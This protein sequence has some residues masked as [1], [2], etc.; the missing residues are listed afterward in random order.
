MSGEVNDRPRV[1][2]EWLS[3]M[4]FREVA[5]GTRLEFAPGINLVLGMNGS[6][7]TTLLDLIAACV[8]GD[9]RTYADETFELSYGLRAGAKVYEFCVS[10]LEVEAD[11]ALREV[12]RDMP[13]AS[14]TRRA[15]ASVIERDGARERSKVEV[16]RDRVVRSVDGQSEVLELPHYLLAPLELSLPVAIWFMGIRRT[17]NEWR[18]DDPEERFGGVDSMRDV[19]RFD[20]ALG[21]FLTVTTQRSDDAYAFAVMDGPTSASLLP[22]MATPRGF[23]EAAYALQSQSTDRTFRLDEQHLPVLGHI[24][25]VAGF[26]RVAMVFSAPEERVQNDHIVSFYRSPDFLCTRGDGQ[27]VRHNHLSFGQKRLLAFFYY[28]A[29]TPDVVVADELVNGLHHGWIARCLH[30]IGD[31]QAFL[32]SQNP[33]LVDMMTFRGADELRRSFVVCRAD[34]EPN[35]PR[36]RL[37]LRW[38]PL[39]VQ[40][41]EE[42]AGLLSVDVQPA[43]EILLAMGLW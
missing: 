10:N 19:V 7:K 1:Q 38:L 2:L 16:T 6:G 21:F 31:R 20:E 28:V 11:P 8:R 40:Q 32:T 42:F 17:H 34:H 37:I 41:A 15:I 36:R 25:E 14:P 12:L 43:S 4:R 29:C 22:R 33:L 23:A 9:F 24:A 18:L 3:I 27:V 26:E 30:E 13:R 5:P 39:D 35:D